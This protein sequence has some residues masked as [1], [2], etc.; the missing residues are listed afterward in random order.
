MGDRDVRIGLALGLG[1]PALSL[2][3]GL[4]HLRLG[5]QRSLRGL[6]LGLDGLLELARERDVVDVQVVDADRVGREAVAQR[7]EHGGAD[8]LAVGRDLDGRELDGL[9]LE[10][11]VEVV[12][13][14]P[15]EPVGADARDQAAG[16]LGS[17]GVVDR[18]RDEDVLGL[19]R[20]RLEI[21]ERLLLHL[22]VDRVVGLPGRDQRDARLDLTRDAAERAHDADVPGI[23]LRKAEEHGRE[24]EDHARRADRQQA[25]VRGRHSA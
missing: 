25:L 19:L 12:R 3:L 23:D 16:I 20:E 1:D 6:L 10:R 5:A 21:V 9:V 11:L 8:R 2:E 13:H 4:L 7:L 24:D 22:D 17:D 18:R 15:V 14:E